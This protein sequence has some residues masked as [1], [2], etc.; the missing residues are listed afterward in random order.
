MGHVVEIFRF[1]TS[2]YQFSTILCIY[3]VYKISEVYKQIQGQSVVVSV[4]DLKRL[5]TTSYS[6]FSVQRKK[7]SHSLKLTHKIML[8]DQ[9]IVKCYGKLKILT[10]NNGSILKLQFLE[11][12]KTEECP[13]ILCICK[14]SSGWLTSKIFASC[15]KYVTELLRCTHMCV[16][17]GICI[18]FY[19]LKCKLLREMN[20]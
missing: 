19:L 3:N 7:N 5:Q 11:I 18:I 13:C 10:Y 17:V 4:T 8:W 1:S 14:S 20:Q 16:C 9:I 15:H 12:I 2:I 6:L